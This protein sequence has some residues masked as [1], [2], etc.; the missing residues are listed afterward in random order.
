MI[1]QK[2]RI[3][4]KSNINYS[5]LYGKGITYTNLLDPSLHNDELDATIVENIKN[6]Y[7][8]IVIYGSYHRGMP[9]YDLICQI[10]KP[11]EI[12]LLCGEDIHKC[13]YNTFLKKGH[14][15]FVREI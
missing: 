8:D 5:Q 3:F 6:K 10:Y 4:I 7:Y 14:S 12:I 9:H 11:N 1:I 15:L 13:N 2:Y